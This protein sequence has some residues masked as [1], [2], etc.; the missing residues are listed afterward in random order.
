MF[1]NPWN[2]QEILYQ[3]DRETESVSTN[4]QKEKEVTGWISN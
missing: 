2:S 1:I 3:R 4:K